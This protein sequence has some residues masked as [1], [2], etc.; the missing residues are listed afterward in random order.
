LTT[1]LKFW[2]REMNIWLLWS[3][4]NPTFWNHGV[5]HI[6]AHSPAPVTLCRPRLH[7]SEATEL[8]FVRPLELNLRTGDLYIKLEAN[9]MRSQPGRATKT[10]L[11]ETSLNWKIGKISKCVGTTIAQSVKWLAAKLLAG[12]W[13]TT[14]SVRFFLYYEF[15]I[16]SGDHSTSCIMAQ[17]EPRLKMHGTIFLAS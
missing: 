17:T 2:Q 16:V 4:C 8:N 15:Q 7:C 10:K 5:N 1:S 6:G 12:T 14:G 13:P 9:K 11:Q 3:Q